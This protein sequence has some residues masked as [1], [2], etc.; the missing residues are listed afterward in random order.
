MTDFFAATASSTSFTQ[1]GHPP[2]TMTVYRGVRFL[3]LGT[4]WVQGAMSLRQPD[5]IELAYVQMMMIWTLF[6]RQPQH[7]VQLGLGSGALTKF[8][9]HQFPHAR[10]T[11]V[12]LNPNVIAI[13]STW[14]CL[15]PNDNRLQVLEMNASDFVGDPANHQQIDILQVDLYDELARGPVLDSPE[16][17]QACHACLR[18]D[19][20]MTINLFGDIDHYD[21]SLA[22]IAEVFD[23]V[24]WLP[25]GKDTN[26][27]VIAF[28]TAPQIDFA[29][30]HARA[31][32]IKVE[33]NLKAKP[34]V[35]G[36][37]DWMA[38]Q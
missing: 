1:P 20:I 6:T 2:A 11:A 31:V 3:H 18:A 10:V 21:E 12:E 34:W 15:P 28:K 32:Q 8:C 22:R 38:G 5:A 19:G 25:E 33:L 27:V 35:L 7:I 23:A 24:V 30:L 36:L 17:Y 29:V 37:Q 13:C 4:S 26:I 16:F 9:Y 14:F